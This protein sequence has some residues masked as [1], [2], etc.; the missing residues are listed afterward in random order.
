MLPTNRGREGA[1]V[2]AFN[3][4]PPDLGM[5]PDEQKQATRAYYAATSFM[6]AQV[7]KVLDAPE[8]SGLK[9]NTLVIFWGDHGFNLGQHGLWTKQ[10]LFED[11][12]RVPLIVYDPSQK[13][14]GGVV[15]SPV[16]FVDAYPTLVQAC[17]L[18]NPPQ[19]LQ[20]QSLRPLLDDPALPFKDAAYTQIVRYKGKGGPTFMGRSVRTA[21]YRYNEWDEGREGVE[22]YDEQNDA[23]E[24]RN[25]APDPAQAAV[26]AEMQRTLRRVM[27]PQAEV[28]AA[29]TN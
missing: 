26:V 12:A 4:Q 18:P 28:V 7:G 2:V 20:G 17:A 1:P 24:T 3:G 25:L 16:E 15:M 5:T 19:K 14:R 9:D 22:L 6:D 11:S 13:A 8:S 10:N 23:G 27:P 21:R 29:A